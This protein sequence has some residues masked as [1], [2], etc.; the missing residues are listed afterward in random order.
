MEEPAEIMTDRLLRDLL[1]A[2]RNNNSTSTVVFQGGGWSVGLLILA[3]LITAGALYV[4]D[5][6]KD[7]VKAVRLEQ[8]VMRNEVMAEIRDLRNT[9]NAIRAYINTGRMPTQAKEK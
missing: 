2:G 4:A 1:M 7:E 8:Q 3:A 6:A 5:D 9:D